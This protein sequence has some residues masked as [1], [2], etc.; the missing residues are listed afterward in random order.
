MERRT[1]F[2]SGN[3]TAVKIMTN[4]KLGRKAVFKNRYL[5]IWEIAVG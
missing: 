1:R 5:G 3:V 2:T 4:L